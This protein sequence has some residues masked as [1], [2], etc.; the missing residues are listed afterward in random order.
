MFC[1]EN[2]VIYKTVSEYTNI[3]VYL[4]F[5]VKYFLYYYIESYV[6]CGE[7]WN[8]TNNILLY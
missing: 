7:T 4:Q 1:E 6:I 3:T 8:L 2:I 5:T